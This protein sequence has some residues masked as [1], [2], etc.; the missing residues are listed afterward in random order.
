M[1]YVRLTIVSIALATVLSCSGELPEYGSSTEVQESVQPQNPGISGVLNVEFTEEMTMHIESS[2]EEALLAEMS[3]YGITS[4]TRMFPDAGEW[5]ARHR[6]AGLHRWYKVSYD[7]AT[8]AT[9]AVAAFSEIPGAASVEV[10][11]KMRSSATGIPFNDRYAGIQWNLYNSAQIEGYVAGADINVLPLWEI[12]CGSSEVIVNVVD[13]G[14]EMSHEDL[15][16]V[17]IPAGSNGSKCFVNGHTG[18]RIVPGLH[19]THVAGTI[20]AISNNGKGIAGIA[21]GNDGKGGVRILSSQIFMEDGDSEMQGDAEAGI[22]WGADHGALISQNSWGYDYASEQEARSSGTPR[23]LKAAVDYFIKNAGCDANGEQVGLMKGGIVVF[24]AGNEGWAYAHPADYEPVIAVGAIGPDGR[25][26]GYSNYGEWVDICAPGGEYETFSQYDEAMIL[27]PGDG[28]YYFM[29]GTSMACPHVS[30][31]AALLISA[32]GGPGF[33]NEELKAIL[34]DGANY[35]FG[36]SEMVGPLLDAYG[37]YKA[38]TGEEGAPV[39]KSDYFGRYSIRGHEKLVVNYTASSRKSKVTLDIKCD[40][41]ARYRISGERAEV[42]FNDASGNWTGRHA[43]TITATNES[44]ESTT[45]T[46]DYTIMENHAPYVLR[47]IED[48]VL[49]T[50]GSSIEESLAS[51]FRDDDGGELSYSFSC[52]DDS[53]F[54]SSLRDGKLSLNALRNGAATITVTA[55]D[56]CGLSCSTSFRAGVFDG[57]NGPEIYPLPIVEC[58]HVCVAGIS[59]TDVTIYNAAGKKLYT[60]HTQGASVLDPVTVDMSTFAPGRYRVEVKYLNR[61]FKRDVTKK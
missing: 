51:V 34:L 3:E 59:D 39:I 32:L 52:S 47:P 8:P 46:I 20:A 2:A 13:H 5:E 27:A 6:E 26:T 36:A 40:G 29:A 1:R 30:G 28:E 31:V 61:T 56:P 24:A 17:C 44:G 10:P 55:K 14:V 42:T 11:M 35:S 22:V 45:E 19:G 12:S 50:T 23:S 16:G 7:P 48:Q 25:R 33:T 57:S 54:S 41:S 4:M 37:A 18:Y 43:L 21:G 53:V 49:N 60:G 9:K 58:M 15:E 38:C